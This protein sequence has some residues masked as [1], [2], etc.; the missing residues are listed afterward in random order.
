MNDKTKSPFA[1]IKLTEQTPL[2]QAL[3]QQLFT[4]TPRPTPKPEEPAAQPLSHTDGKPQPKPPK[5]EQPKPHA[6]ENTAS[7]LATS[8]PPQTTTPEPNTASLE[9]R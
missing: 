5:P 6:S 4:S 3:D 1:G 8:P 7:Q 2:G 9:F